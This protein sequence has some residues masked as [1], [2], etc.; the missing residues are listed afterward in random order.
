MFAQVG[1]VLWYM[2]EGKGIGGANNVFMVG[3][4]HGYTTKESVGEA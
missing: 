2:H 1:V 3:Y 4:V